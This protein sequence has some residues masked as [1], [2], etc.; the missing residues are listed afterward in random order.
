MNIERI[1]TITVSTADMVALIKA[2]HPRSLPVQGIPEA[3][4]R[5]AVAVTGQGITLTYR[6]SVPL[7]SD[8]T[9]L[10]VVQA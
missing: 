9:D 8:V 7:L 3:M 4:G 6:N 5:V 10:A 2:A 1:H